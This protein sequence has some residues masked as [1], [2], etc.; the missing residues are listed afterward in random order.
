VSGSAWAGLRRQCKVR[1]QQG[2]AVMSLSLRLFLSKALKRS[3]SS[4]FATAGP[5]ETSAA[6][7]SCSRT[8]TSPLGPCEIWQ[9]PRRCRGDVSVVDERFLRPF[10]R[11]P[12]PPHAIAH[13]PSLT[14]CFFHSSARSRATSTFPTGLYRLIDKLYQGFTLER[15]AQEAQGSGLYCSR[16]RPLLGESGHEDD[17][18]PPTLRQ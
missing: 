4:Y 9:S 6:C 11:P 5:A 3:P 16:P 13:Q 15:F 1:W 18:G 2:I 10:L 14:Y 8:R 7:L 17:G 12:C